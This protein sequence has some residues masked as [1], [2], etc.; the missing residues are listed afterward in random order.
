MTGLVGFLMLALRFCCCFLKEMIEKFFSPFCEVCYPERS[1]WALTSGKKVVYPHA[2]VTTG[3]PNPQGHPWAPTPC[4]CAPALQQL[5]L[6]GHQAG[7]LQWGPHP[8][9]PY[10]PG[11]GE[12]RKGRDLWGMTSH[13]LPQTSFDRDTGHE[14]VIQ[15]KHCTKKTSHEILSATKVIKT[16]WY[17]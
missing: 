8:M 16:P 11:P 5:S 3:L 14:D 12:L 17:L 4:P 1:L 9:E 15:N 7:T 10:F 2:W 6:P 13:C